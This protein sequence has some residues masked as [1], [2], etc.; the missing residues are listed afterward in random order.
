MASLA[1]ILAL[2]FFSTNVHPEW[3]MIGAALAA[4]YAIF[5]GLS[6]IVGLD[7]DD[8][9]IVAAIQRRFLVAVGRTASVSQ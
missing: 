3:I 4:G 7:D 9:M 5:C 1:A 8:R 2:R 6:L